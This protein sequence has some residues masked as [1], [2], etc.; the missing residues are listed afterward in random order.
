MNMLTVKEVAAQ[1]GVSCGAIYKAASNGTLKH[2]RIGVTIRISESQLQDW[3]Q[4]IEQE[5]SK[6]SRPRQSFSHLNL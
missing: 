5:V 3:L 1:L 2:Y 6:T 4:T